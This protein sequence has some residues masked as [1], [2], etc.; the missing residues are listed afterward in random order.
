[1][2]I[3]LVTGKKNKKKRT[4]NRLVAYVSVVLGLHNAVARIGLETNSSG[5][6]LL[7]TEK[8]PLPQ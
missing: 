4:K 1:M 8:A 6:V 3:F 2:T 7:G 5:D